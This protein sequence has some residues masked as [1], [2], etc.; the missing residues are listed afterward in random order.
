MLI[1]NVVSNYINKDFLQKKNLGII[2]YNTISDTIPKL[3]YNVPVCFYAELKAENSSI[4][5]KGKI[6]TS[7]A[8]VLKKICSF[9]SPSLLFL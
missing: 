8:E 7:L 9:S 1:T 5:E 2:A 3:L 4:N 6:N